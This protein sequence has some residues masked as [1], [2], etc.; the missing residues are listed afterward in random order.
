MF[1]GNITIPY[2]NIKLIEKCS[3]GFFPMGIAI[4]YENPENGEMTEDRFSMS[5]R[6]K[7]IDFLREKIGA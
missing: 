2:E 4:T 7:W 3:Q 5:N 6:Q 1:G